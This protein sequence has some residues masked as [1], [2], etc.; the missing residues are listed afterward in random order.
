LVLFPSFLEHKYSIDYGIEPFRFIN[1][2]L[3]A[4]KKQNEF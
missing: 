2:N 4:I 1:F 3:K